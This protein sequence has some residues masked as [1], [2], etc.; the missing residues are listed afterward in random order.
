MNQSS[1]TIESRESILPHVVTWL[2]QHKCRKLLRQCHYGL[3]KANTMIMWEKENDHEI[4]CMQS[5]VQNTRCSGRPH[6]C[7]IHWLSVQGCLVQV[8][9]NIELDAVG[10][11]FE[12]RTLPVVFASV[13][14]LWSDLG[15]SPQT[16]LVLNCQPPLFT[17][18]K[19]KFK[20]MTRPDSIGSGPV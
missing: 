13:V 8:D 12:F 17:L 16:V 7:G 14:P 1:K 4:V 11:Q 6:T 3:L 18:Y 5:E 10:C 19:F 9:N 2:S 15:C 20:N